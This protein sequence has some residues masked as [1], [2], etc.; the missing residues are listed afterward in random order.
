MNDLRD[1]RF[2]DGNRKARII[3]SASPGSARFIF[4]GRTFDYGVPASASIEVRLFGDSNQSLQIGPLPQQ[5]TQVTPVIQSGPG[6]PLIVGTGRPL[7]VALAGNRSAQ[8]GPVSSTRTYRGTPGIVG[9]DIL[10]RPTDAAVTG[11][12][13][14][15]RAKLTLFR[16]VN[17]ADQVTG[18]VELVG[19]HDPVTNLI[20]GTVTDS[21]GNV[22]TFEGALFGPSREFA[23]FVFE[24]RR[25]QDANVRSIGYLTARLDPGAGGN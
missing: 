4:G 11:G 17:G 24:F 9:E 14:G 21:T 1:V 7:V 25:P 15:I 20:S 16:R 22:G 5:P 3:Y 2:L 8:Q 19:A 12:S 10:A 23:G 18:E 13:Q 6:S